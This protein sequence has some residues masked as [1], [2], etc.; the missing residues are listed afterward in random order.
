MQEIEVQDDF[1]QSTK[2]ISLADFSFVFYTF[3]NYQKF[4]RQMN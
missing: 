2:I 4:L 3:L 1:L